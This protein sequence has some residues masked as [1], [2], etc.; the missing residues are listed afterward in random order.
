MANPIAFYIETLDTAAFN[1]AESGRMISQHDVPLLPTIAP[2]FVVGPI[3]ALIGSENM[4][5]GLLIMG[6]LIL[7]VVGN[8]LTTLFYYRRVKT[9]RQQI[10]VGTRRDG[11]F[12]T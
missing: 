3:V 10:A 11:P 9:Y 6:G 7:S 2:W 12:S 1:K 5:A 4:V 8:V